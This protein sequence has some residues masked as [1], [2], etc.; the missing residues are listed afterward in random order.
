MY[1]SIEEAKEEVWKRWND[2]GLRQRVLEYVGELPEGLGR[3]PWAVMVRHIVTPNFEFLRFTE[4]VKKTGLKPC[5]QEYTSDKF[6]TWN[7]DKL[8]LGKITFFHGKGKGNGDKITPHRIIDFQTEDGQSFRDIRTAWGESF[9][10]FHH[11]L[12][13]AKKPEI[14]KFDIS[15]WYRKMG[16]KPEFFYHR[17]IALFVCHGILFENFLVEGDEGRFTR[18]IAWPAI[19]KITDHFGIKPLIVRL[20]PEESEASPYWCRYPGHLEAEVKVLLAGGEAATRLHAVEGS[21]SG[22]TLDYSP[23]WK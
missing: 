12:V 4:R 7:P 11:K 23:S 3:E 13:F 21:T 19:Q 16:S 18:E 2:A 6:C 22:L 15:A 17:L 9:I 1:T 20:L 14:E 10:T 8:L 5:C